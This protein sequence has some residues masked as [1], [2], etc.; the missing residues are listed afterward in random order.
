MHLVPLKFQQE[1]K[2][3]EKYILQSVL[4][5]TAWFINLFIM[6]EIELFNLQKRNNPSINYLHAMF[7]LA[8]QACWIDEI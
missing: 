6:I 3:V 5:Q 7:I 2:S 4:N 8:N 1:G